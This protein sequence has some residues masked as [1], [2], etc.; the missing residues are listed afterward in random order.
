M[1]IMPENL[2]ARNLKQSYEWFSKLQQASRYAFPMH[3]WN[4]LYDKNIKGKDIKTIEELNLT[5]AKR[6]AII[7]VGLSGCGKSSYAYDFIKKYPNFKLISVDKTELDIYFNYIKE[8]GYLIPTQIADMITTN[9]IGNQLNK[10]SKA[11]ENLI[12]DGQFVYSNARGALIKT[13]RKLGYK[14]IIIFSFLN[15]SNDYIKARLKS[16]AL[17][18]AMYDEYAK[19]H[20]LIEIT[21]FRQS[22]LGKDTTEMLISLKPILEWEKMQN[23]KKMYS[24]LYTYYFN[25]EPIQCGLKFQKDYDLLRSGVNYMFNVF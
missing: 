21:E 2:Y 12:I 14:N 9:E 17:E 8:K 24:E 23:Y 13:L 25:G 11:G 4:Q 1:N 18:E 22:Y 7:L 20:S 19:T 16:R 6:T 3:I 10:H 15:A 5:T